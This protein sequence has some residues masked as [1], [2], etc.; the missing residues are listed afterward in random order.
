MS[1]ESVR[2]QD[3][4]NYLF[5][6]VNGM[7]WTFCPLW[8]SSELCTEI[9]NCVLQR[10]WKTVMENI[11][12]EQYRLSSMVSAPLFT[13]ILN[14]AQ[15]LNTLYRRLCA[16]LFGCIFQYELGI[17]IFTFVVITRSSFIIIDIGSQNH[18]PLTENV[19]LVIGLA[20]T[21]YGE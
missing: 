5:K 14:C 9:M 2:S 21:V 17:H 13:E 3:I 6:P 16:C 20:N 12:N 1:T 11:K 15:Y 4:Q 19:A 8:F 18:W 7:L 10:Y